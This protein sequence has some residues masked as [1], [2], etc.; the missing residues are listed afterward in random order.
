MAER[1]RRTQRQKKVPTK[2]QLNEL[3]EITKKENPKVNQSNLE[4]EECPCGKKEPACKWNRAPLLVTEENPPEIPWVFCENCNSWWHLHCSGLVDKTGNLFT[5]DHFICIRCLYANSFM[6]KG[7]LIS[8]EEFP[9]KITEKSQITKSS[10]D[11]LSKNNNKSDKNCYIPAEAKR[12]TENNILVNEKKDNNCHKPAEA[13]RPT[14]NDY[15]VSDKPEYIVIIDRIDFT[16]RTSVDILKE[17]QKVY[18]EITPLHCYPLPKGGIAIH[19]ET[20]E[21]EQVLLSEWPI[22]SFRTQRKVHP[23]K[24]KSTYKKT[25]IVKSISAD[26]TD[27]NLKEDLEKTYKVD[28]KV[29]RLRNPNIDKVFPIIKIDTEISIGQTLLNE[30]VYILG[31]YYN[32]EPYVRDIPTRCFKCQKFGHIAKNCFNILTCP[33]CSKNHHKFECTET[34]LKCAN[35]NGSHAAYSKECEIIIAKQKELTKRR[36]I[37]RQLRTNH[38]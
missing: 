28:F 35:C 32:C 10:C 33:L 4:K 6:P 1:P 3:P 21:E 5:L 13:E 16:F 27:E 23:H 20:Q 12:P 2:L 29:T 11:K 17:I 26:K 8:G 36:I 31:H 9:E 37:E 34:I 22:G 38:L 25:L 18:K 14:E 30:G 24:P 19:V 7:T 15:L